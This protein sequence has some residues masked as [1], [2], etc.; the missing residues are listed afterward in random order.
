MASFFDP[1]QLRPEW[2]VTKDKDTFARGL[3]MRAFRD[4]VLG[5]IHSGKFKIRMM[6]PLTDPYWMDCIQIVRSRAEEAVGRTIGDLARERSPHSILEAVYESS[7]EVLFDLLVEDPDTTC[8]D[9][10][11]KREHGALPTFM[12]HPA[13]MPCTDVGILPAQPQRTQRP[14]LEGLY[15]RGV[16]PTAYGLFPHYL[17]TTVRE[18]GVLSLEEAIRKATSLPAGVIGL[19]DRGRLAEGAYA[20]VVLFDLEALQENA[21]FRVPAQAPQGIRCV[22]VNGQVVCEDGAHTGARPGKVLRHR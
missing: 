18:W 1:S 4:K 10:I 15:T 12:A 20:D 22:L 2:L 6:H 17:R 9:Y 8:A 11:D 14:A 21:D 16:S 7:W 5:Y 19:R 3:E 13:G